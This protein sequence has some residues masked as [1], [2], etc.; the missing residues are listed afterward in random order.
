MDGN[1]FE[2]QLEFSTCRFCGRKIVMFVDDPKKV[3]RHTEP[4]PTR[5]GIEILG[6][7]AC[8]RTSAAPIEDSN[9]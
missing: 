9:G 1:V 2:Y 4:H 3:W 5:R 6:K 7:Q 8:R